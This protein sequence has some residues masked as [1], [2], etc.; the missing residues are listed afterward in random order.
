MT[1]KRRKAARA[2]T[3]RIIIIIVGLLALFWLYTIGSYRLSSEKTSIVVTDKRT[4]QIT[5][6]VCIHID[7]DSGNCTRYKEETKKFYYVVTPSEEFE[8]EA[9]L[10]DQIEVNRTYYVLIRGWRWSVLSRR[11]TKIFG[12]GIRSTNQK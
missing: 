7:L 2:T 3:N 8:I 4:G 5:S 12:L 10:Y 9:E 1:S 6:Q 11:I